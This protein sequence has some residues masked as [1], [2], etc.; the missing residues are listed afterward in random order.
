M[1]YSIW[2]F[3]AKSSV[4][5]LPPLSVA[6]ETKLWSWFENEDHWAATRRCITDSVLRA[7]VF[8]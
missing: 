5:F 1:G 7:T 4:L 8:Y 6:L 2:T 3:A